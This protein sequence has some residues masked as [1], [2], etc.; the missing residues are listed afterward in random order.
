MIEF[1]GK[2]NTAKVFTD[3]LEEM[4]ETQIKGIM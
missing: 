3:Q 4:A 2:Y 1:R